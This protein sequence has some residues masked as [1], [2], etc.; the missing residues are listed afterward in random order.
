MLGTFRLI[1][2]NA[3]KNVVRIFQTLEKQKGRRFF[4]GLLREMPCSY[5]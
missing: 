2:S 3:W 4:G 1:F 5:L